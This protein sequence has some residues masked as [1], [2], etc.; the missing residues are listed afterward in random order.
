VHLVAAIPHGL[1][2][3]YMPWSSKLYKEV[4]QP[5]KGELAIPDKPGLGLEF[6]PEAL[7]KWGM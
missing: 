1:T 3:E 4:P 5:A 7:K 2:V 6:D